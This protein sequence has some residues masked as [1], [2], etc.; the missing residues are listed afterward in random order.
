[1]I[2]CPWKIK[3]GENWFLFSWSVALLR[4]ET[5]HGMTV[6]YFPIVDDCRY[7][8]GISEMKVILETI[9][10]IPIIFTDK[11]YMDLKGQLS[12]S[13]CQGSGVN[14]PESL[15][16]QVRSLALISGLRIWHCHEVWC[17]LQTWLGSGISVA[18][19]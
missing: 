9:Y 4:L 10:F 15:R 1:M 14:E 3:P 11:V 16:M 13:S 5:I 8:F 6:F 18:V 17:R 2:P 7:S 19:V 12:W